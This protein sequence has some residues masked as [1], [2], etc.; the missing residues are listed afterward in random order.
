MG[1]NKQ[2]DLIVTIV[3]RGFA[4]DVMD[5]ARSA[6][7]EGGTIMY[8]RGTGIHENAKFFGI[9]IEPEKEIVLNLISSDIKQ[10]VMKAICKNTGLLTPGKGISFS[11][12][13]N[14]VVGIVHLLNGEKDK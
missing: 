7:A 3:N 10:A 5:A 9:A 6:G 13:V 2:F 4:D 1:N 11:L 8:G 12:P 14:D